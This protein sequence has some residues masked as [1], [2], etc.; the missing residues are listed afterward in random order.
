MYSNILG[1]STGNA[2]KICNKINLGKDEDKIEL[3]LFFQCFLQIVREAI[4][5]CD[6]DDL[7]KLSTMIRVTC[8]A[9]DDLHVKST[10][11]KTV[12]DIWVLDIR[13]LRE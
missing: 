8:E 2:F 1:V 3:E 13:R 11:K 4:M 10:N 6:V 5:I 9:V 12:F 7:Q